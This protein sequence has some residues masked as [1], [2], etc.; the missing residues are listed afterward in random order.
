MIQLILKLWSHSENEHFFLLFH[1]YQHFEILRYFS[2]F[3]CREVISKLWSTMAGVPYPNYGKCSRIQY[4]QLRSPKDYF[5]QISKLFDDIWAKF[6][7]SYQFHSFRI[8][9]FLFAIADPRRNPFPSPTSNC[10]AWK[11][12]I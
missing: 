12:T 4:L 8:L 7:E 6:D 9:R 2:K 3:N 5:Y 1:L 10:E 11:L